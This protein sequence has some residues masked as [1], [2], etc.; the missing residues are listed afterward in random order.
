[1]FEGRITRAGI[2]PMPRPDPPLIG[3]TPKR[4]GGSGLSAE[5]VNRR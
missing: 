3:Q 1:M 2:Y 4:V 5:L